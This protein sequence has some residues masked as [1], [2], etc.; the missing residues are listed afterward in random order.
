MK[1]LLLV[2]AFI[3]ATPALADD[4]HDDFA[5]ANSVFE[6]SVSLLGKNDSSATEGLRQSATMYEAIADEHALENSA[7]LTNAANARLLAGQT[8]RAIALYHRALRIDPSDANARTNLAVA[9][10][11]AQADISIDRSTGVVELLTSWRRAL[12]AR[13]R[14]IITISAW[15]AL[16]LWGALRLSGARLGSPTRVAIPIACVACIGAST[17]AADALATNTEPVGVV[18][19]Q[20]SIGRTGPDAAVYDPSF[21]KPLPEGVE[22]VVVDERAGWVLG[23][24]GDGRETW[25]RTN[26]VELIGA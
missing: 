11:R 7:L 13:T 5:R 2:L 26:D 10:T 20:E 3:L 15:S 19:A 14:A 21:T 12:P 4:L 17:L 9:R 25:L 8:G 22:F 24:L 6:A 16:W 18:I 23:R 1:P